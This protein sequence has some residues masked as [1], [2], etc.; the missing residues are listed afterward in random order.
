M[1]R[2]RFWRGMSTQSRQIAIVLTII[3]VMVFV[4]VL[5]TSSQSAQSNT[6]VLS[7][8]KIG[9]RHQSSH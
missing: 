1:W 5:S 2:F 6:W 3:F 8:R 4:S 7:V 9:L